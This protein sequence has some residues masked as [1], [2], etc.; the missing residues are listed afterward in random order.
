LY[1][2]SSCSSLDAS[3]G[4]MIMVHDNTQLP[5]IEVAGIQLAPGLKHKIGYKMRTSQLLPSPYSDCTDTISPA[6]RANF[7][8]YG[9]AD[10]AYSQVLCNTICVQTYL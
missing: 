8:Q 3:A 1:K 10:Y 7:D 4:M 6:M 2:T 9:D 5:F